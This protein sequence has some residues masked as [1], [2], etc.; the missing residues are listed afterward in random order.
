M[1]KVA[2][3]YVS[4]LLGL[5]TAVLM[6]AGAA[7]QARPEDTEVWE[8]VP[9]IVTP[10]A[11]LAPP[12]DAIVLFDGTD[13]S[14][15]E[16]AGG[17]EAGWRVGDGAMTV[18]AGSGGIRTRRGFGDIQLHLEWR[19][20][21]VVSGEGQERGNSGVYLMGRYELQVLDSYENRT[22]S[23]GQAGSIYK[24]YMPLV[25]A[26]RPPGTWQTYD[27]VFTAPRFDDAG[28]L[29]KPAYMTVFHNGVLIQ[30]HEE[31]MGPTL[32]I[33]TPEYE[34]H[35]DRAPIM[36]QDHGNPVSYRNIWVRELGGRP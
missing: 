27:I 17:G 35:P 34:A 19:S 16:R 29:E 4:L 21:S 30:N 23:N 11:D 31:L 15:W 28:R 14:A 12:S 2:R 6:P 1:A 18:A 9:P 24:Q 13:L 3:G 8:P 10:G 36:L 20:P 7:G 32:F 26:S 25:N 22:Y 33:G 5:A